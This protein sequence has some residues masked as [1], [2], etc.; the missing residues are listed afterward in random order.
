MTIVND[1]M[2]MPWLTGWISEPYKMSRNL[3]YSAPYLNNVVYIL[4]DK[5]LAMALN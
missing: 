4:C 2:L 3:K 1:G 5:H